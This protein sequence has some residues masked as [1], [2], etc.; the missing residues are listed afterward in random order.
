MV[1][2]RRDTEPTVAVILQGPNAETLIQEK[3]NGEAESL[4]DQVRDYMTD[5]Q[6]L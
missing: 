5:M 2:M 4:K 3:F 6:P 1:Q